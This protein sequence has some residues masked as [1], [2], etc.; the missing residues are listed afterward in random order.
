MQQLFARY[1][2]DHVALSFPSFRA[3]TLTPEFMDMI[4]QIRKTGFTIAPEAGSERL[5]AVINKN[6]TE[7]EI[8]E[9]VS[10]AFQLGWKVFKLYF[11]IGLPTETDDDIIAIADLVNRI[12]NLR[13]KAGGRRRFMPACPPLSPNPTPRFNGNPSWVLGNRKRKLRNCDSD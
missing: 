6:I 7:A 8:M 4:R 13:G 5:R 9:T 1:A 11:M 12:K 2:D 3:G 10:N